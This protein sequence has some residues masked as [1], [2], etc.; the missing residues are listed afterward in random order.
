MRVTPG[1]ASTANGV[2]PGGGSRV[3][4]R[5][6]P[7]AARGSALVTSEVSSVR[8]P[9]TSTPPSENPFICNS[10]SA[11]AAAATAEANRAIDELLDEATQTIAGQAAH[12]AT[13][14]IEVDAL[15]GRDIVHDSRVRD[16]H[17]QIDQTA[18]THDAEIQGLTRLGNLSQSQVAHVANLATSAMQERDEALQEAAA[19]GDAA[20][21]ER[22]WRLRSQAQ[23]THV[24]SLAE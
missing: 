4:G 15:R 7:E 18:A 5:V 9:L 6:T 8:L 19:A 12:I 11:S 14:E 22:P 1:A 23:V 13:Q 16:L 24:A 2:T 17:D 10:H 21:A 20:E 3:R